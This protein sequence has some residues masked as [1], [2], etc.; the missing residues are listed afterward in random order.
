MKGP[1]FHC[2]F[3]KYLFVSYLNTLFTKY[4]LLLCPQV[5]QVYGRWEEAPDPV[6][7][8][9]SHAVLPEL[10]LLQS[11][12]WRRSRSVHCS[13]C[14]LWCWGG[15]FS[16]VRRQ[17]WIFQPKQKT[18]KCFTR[19]LSLWFYCMSFPN[20]GQVW[21]QLKRVCFVDRIRKCEIILMASKTRVSTYPAPYLDDYGETDPNLV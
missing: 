18:W 15:N 11:A 8:L 19:F 5:S 3:M 17:F 9:W 16:Q 2:V 1:A 10:L 4:F 20:A 13:R 21:S 6:S 12:R 14:H 7:V